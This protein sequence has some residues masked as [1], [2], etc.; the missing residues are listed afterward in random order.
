VPA[1]AKTFVLDFST[2]PM[3]DST[4]MHLLKSF[5][6]KVTAHGAP[7]YITATRGD[8]RHALVANGLKPPLVRYA[9]SI[10]DALAAAQK[11]SIT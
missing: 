9:A 4:G 10:D 3:V 8:V 5:A 1:R 6:K 11:E 2:V 7:L